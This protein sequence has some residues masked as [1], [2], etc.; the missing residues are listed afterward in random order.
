MKLSNSK[1]SMRGVGID[2]PLPST[3]Y[4][5]VGRWRCQ[6]SDNQDA[7]SPFFDLVERLVFMDVK[8]GLASSSMLL[9]TTDL[10]TRLSW[11]SG[12]ASRG[13]LCFILDLRVS[14]FT[15]F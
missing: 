11:L 5:G 15:G 9:H 14:G 8:G 7:R 3:D 1:F 10:D 6:R 4:T 2:P 13:M 12:L